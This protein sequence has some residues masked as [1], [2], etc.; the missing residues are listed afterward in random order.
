VHK[1]IN[2]EDI[3]AYASTYRNS[4]EEEKDLIEFYEDHEGD[5]SKILDYIVLSRNED[6]PRFI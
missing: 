3:T 2:E 5:V 1:E 6:I 4:K